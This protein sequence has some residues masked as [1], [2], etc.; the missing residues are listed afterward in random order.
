M[1]LEVKGVVVLT[2]TD[3]NMYIMYTAL[4]ALFSTVYNVQCSDC[5]TSSLLYITYNAL[6]DLFSTVYNVHCSDWPLLYCI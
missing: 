3:G 2:H 6:T 5:P 4:T 1:L